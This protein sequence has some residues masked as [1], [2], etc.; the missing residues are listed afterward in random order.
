MA[1][2]KLIQDWPDS[3]KAIFHSS[4]KEFAEFG[5][6]GA[7]VDRIAERAGCNKA[8]IY[9]H[10]KSKNELYLETVRLM[11]R[12]A[13]HEL[14]SR[15]SQATS[16]EEFLME[17]SEAYHEVF[18]NNRDYQPIIFREMANPNPEVIDEIA[19]IVGGSRLMRKAVRLLI[20]DRKK[21]LIREIPPLHAVLS[22]A[23]MNAGYFMLWRIVNRALKID[24][25]ESFLNERKQSSLDI[26]LNGVKVRP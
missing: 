24:D 17:L 8:M 10:F 14:E 16:F 12:A 5:R 1:L 3:K 26:F 6:D 13:R 20:R 19:A 25:M 22:F 11:Y 4:L 18:L 9:Y 2:R 23:M 15:V 7:R 21:G